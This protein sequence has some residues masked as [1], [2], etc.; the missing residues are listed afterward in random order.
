MKTTPSENEQESLLYRLYQSLPLGVVFLDSRGKVL[1][2]NRQFRR[3]FPYFAEGPYGLPLCRAIQC[4]RGFGGPEVCG[5]CTLRRGV[6]RIAEDGVPMKMAKWSCR[7][8]KAVRWFQISG[9]PVGDSGEKYAA[10]FFT[11]ITDRVREESALRKRMKL[12]LATG[13]LNRDGFV[14]TFESLLR[15]GRGK[16]FTLCMTDL[17]DFKEINDRYGHPT[18][19]QVLRTFAKVAR[20]NIRAGDA[21]GRYGG[22]EFLFLFQDA[23]PRQ[24]A[25]V[26]RRIQKE[27]LESCRGIV[28]IPVTF[29]AGMMLWSGEGQPGLRWKDC[30][31]AADRLLYRAKQKGKNRIVTL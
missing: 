25:E 24:A 7:C 20:K 29:S 1:S 19:D 26:I 31:K 3:Y 21:I 28:P 11:E 10:L 27:L 23:A 22:D 9:V 13:A 15:G 4:R 30:V 18:G 6:R 2:V 12:D 16:R 17:D 5:S 8:R 14:Q